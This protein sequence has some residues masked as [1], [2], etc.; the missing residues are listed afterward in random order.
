MS[1]PMLLAL[2]A[3]LT[4]STAAFAEVPSV[5]A[6]VKPLHSLVA[7]V[8]GDL[9]TPSLIVDGSASPHT[10][11]LKPSDARALQQAD[12]VFWTGHGLELFLEDAIG[13]LAPNAT[14]VELAETPGIELLPPREG[15]AFEAHAHDDEVQDDH[16]HE[17]HGHDHG[18]D[19]GHEHAPGSEAHDH[20]HH[21]GDDHDHGAEAHAD[22]GHDHHAGH[23]HAGHDH[24]HGDEDMHFF[25]DPANA[26]LMVSAIAASL[27]AADPGNADVYRANAAAT[28]D[29]L[30]ALITE[31]D[32]R[33]TPVKDRPFV[34]FHDA[35]QYFENRFGLNVAGSITINPEL[36]P[37]AERIGE[38]RDR[39]KSADAACVFAEPN[40]EP[41][42][43]DVL[44][45][46]T[47]ARAGVLDPEGASLEPGP[48]LYRQLIE[49]LATGLVDCLR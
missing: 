14:V 1:R 40:F 10:Y 7:A 34:V 25:L 49:N 17:D 33:L 31:T 26:K 35:Y 21:D 11:S 8:M 3:S 13:T 6:S 41:K 32:A 19:D 23:D 9:G 29:D 46:G 44:I 12:I 39:L 36:A 15:G 47:G 16:A 2:A 4:M 42:V 18:H 22:D 24:A 48:G 38:I 43:V 37:G 5:V 28:S 27:A 30:D 20:D 45:E